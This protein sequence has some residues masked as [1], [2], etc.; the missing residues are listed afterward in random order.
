MRVLLSGLN[1][2]DSAVVRDVKAKGEIKRRLLDMG[3][4]RGVQFTVIRIAPL[5]DPIVIKIKGFDL[6]L[7]KEEAASITVETDIKNDQFRGLE[8]EK[9]FS[10][11]DS[12]EKIRNRDKKEINVALL[13]NPNSGKTSLFNC[14]AG[15]HQKVGNFSGV[16]VEKYE[17]FI[18]Y[19]DYKINLIDLPGTYSLTA[20]SPE[21]VV[22]RNYI[23]EEKPDVV[24]DVIDGTNLERNLYLTT[25]LMELEVDALYA[26]NM[27]DEVEKQDIK[28]DLRQLQTLLGSHVVTTSAAKNIGIERL[29]DHVIRVYEGDINI[30]K[31]KLIYSSKIETHIIKIKHLLGSDAYLSDRYNLYWLAVKLLENDQLVY[32]LVKQRSVWIKVE[33]ALIEAMDSFEKI[34]QRDPEIVITEDR[35]SFIRG[36]IRETVQIPQ[37]VQKTLTDYID[38]IVLNRVLG[39]PIFFGIMW[40]IFQF[41]FTIGQYPMDWLDS[42]FGILAN[43][44]SSILPDGF[45]KSLIVDGIISGVGGVLIFVPNILLLFLSISI[46]EAS[47]YMARAAFVVDKAMH[48]IG[49]HGKSFIPMITGF[50]CSV[51]AIMACR[52]LK[53]KA[54]RI[55][56][57][58]IITFMSCG[59]RLPVYILL[60][61]AFFKPSHS[62][63]IL[64]GVYMFGVLIALLSA[65]V[66]KKA[67]FNDQSEPFV[68]ELPPYRRPKASSIMHQVSF[69][70]GMY[71]KKAGTIILAASVLIWIATNYPKSENITADFNVIRT[72][73]SQNSDLNKNK[74]DELIKKA[75]RDESAAQIEQ[76]IAGRLGKITEPLI[77]P[78]GFDWKIGVALTAGL[79]AKEIIVSTMNTIYSLEDSESS[80]SFT[81]GFKEVS[82]Y[83]TAAA[84]AL[85]IF[86]LLYAPCVAASV[87]FHRESGRWKYTI[88]MF[89]YTMSVAWIMSFI[90][91][92]IGLLVF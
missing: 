36:A 15:T 82:G 83:S 28:I 76:S 55:T 14:M 17:G 75:D 46:M 80:G 91:Y 74:I 4:C 37:K 35:H 58:M 89:S 27:Y 64:F 2:G 23:I 59:A 84:L 47:G 16:T 5:G 40:L 63:N 41:T 25:Q 49:L 81:T 39:L 7:R 60:I 24:I 11:V 26:I 38:D 66:L 12:P 8:N 92:R 48:R 54:D 90:V 70:A 71:V 44:V 31:N 29:L 72:E 77:K 57:M 22:A 88:L 21:E 56:T 86:V 10:P 43:T 65:F 51:P 67:V 32:E 30:K 61:G 34:Y 33:R 52:T 78:L 87:V 73:I 3:L 79:A 13:G 68:M 50:G 62:G 1:I 18:N 19:K 20:Y 45:L 69:K 53:N 6:S 42:F 85:M 9:L